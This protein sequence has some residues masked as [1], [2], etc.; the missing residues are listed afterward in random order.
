[1]HIKKLKYI[2]YVLFII[3]IIIPLP[4]N[5]ISMHTLRI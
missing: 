5:N 1:M 3:I 2:Y 4:L